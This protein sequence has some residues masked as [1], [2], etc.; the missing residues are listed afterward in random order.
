MTDALA[1]THAPDERGILTTR[2]TRVLRISED[3]GLAI[4]STE[5]R[6]FYP[7]RLS[8]LLLPRNLRVL[9]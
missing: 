4:S 7:D 5:P 2:I 8:H 9:G 1:W 3:I 6:G